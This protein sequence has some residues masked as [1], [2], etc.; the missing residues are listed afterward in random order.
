MYF[1]FLLHLYF[2]FLSLN[3]NLRSKHTLLDYECRRHIFFKKIACNQAFFFFLYF[4]FSYLCIIE[5][6]LFWG[7]T[8]EI[9]I[10]MDLLVLRFPESENYIFS[11][12]LVWICVWMPFINVTQKQIITE[13]QNFIFH[14]C[15]VYKC[16]LK[17]FLW[18][19]DK[20]SVYGAY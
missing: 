15:I 12:W 4:N 6:V 11:W 16:Y 13:T 18:R 1:L 2:I 17:L 14:I 5:K 10:L 8:F 3:C 7:Q 9:E 19:S 20:Y